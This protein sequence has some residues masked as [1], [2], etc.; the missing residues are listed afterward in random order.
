MIQ[1][2]AGQHV[3]GDVGDGHQHPETVALGLA[4][5]RIVEIPGI[6]A[7]DGHER[8]GAQVQAPLLGGLRHLRAQA[9]DFLLHF[10][11]HHMGQRVGMDGE[12]RGHARGVAF[13]HDPGDAA[14][15]FAVLAGLLGDLHHHHL[16]VAR[17]AA[18]FPRDLHRVGDAG[19]VRH[20]V[21][22]T[23][24]FHV[25]ARQLAGVA[26]QH[27]HHGA[28]GAAAVSPRPAPAPRPDRRA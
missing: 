28:F 22:H 21:A 2:R 26:F 12:F 27:V 14:D 3:M 18:L 16:P 1:R 5:H 23:V 11:W 24:F 25:A 20:Q 6:L 13:A 8:R 7:V 19:V 10:R 9:P 17:T 4:V 15:D